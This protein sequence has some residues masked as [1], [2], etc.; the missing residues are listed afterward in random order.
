MNKSTAQVI[1]LFIVICLNGKNVSAQALDADSLIFELDTLSEVVVVATSVKRSANG[2]EYFVTK[3]MR[4]KSEGSALGLIATIPGVQLNKMNNSLSI[5]NRSNILLLINGKS[6]SVDYIRNVDPTNIVRITVNKN[7]KGQ[8]ASEGYDAVIDIKLRAFDGLNVNASNLLIVNPNNNSGD[9]VMMEQPGSSFTFSKNK[10]SFFGAYTYGNS[11]WN[12]PFDEALDY[13]DI[14]DAYGSGMDRY[15]YIGNVGNIGMNYNISS[16]QA[17]SFELDYRHENISDKKNISSDNVL[18]NQSIYTQSKTPV[19]GSTIFYKGVFGDKFDVYNEFGFNTLDN[20]NSNYL[21]SDTEQYDFDTKFK[22]SRRGLKYVTDINSHFSEVLSLNFGYQLN[23][24]KYSSSSFHYVN[25]GNKLWAYLNYTPT[26]IFEL[27][28]GAALNHEYMDGNKYF[29][30]LPSFQVQY[31]PSSVVNFQVSYAANNETPTLFMLNP[32]LTALNP[33][34]YQVGNI[35]LKTCVNHRVELSTTLFNIITFSPRYSYNRNKLLNYASL[36][37]DRIIFQYT[38]T[39][40]KEASFPISIDYPISDFL[41]LSVGGAYYVSKGKLAGN[42]RTID[43][44]WY[45]GN[46]TFFK[47]GYMADLGYSRT[48]VKDNILQGYTQSGI[49][50]WTLTANKQWFGGNLT[51]TLTWFMPLKWGV[52]ESLS[53]VRLTDFYYENT[54]MSM[55]PYRNAMIFQVAYRFDSGKAKK[56]TKRNGIENEK[57]IS[58]GLSF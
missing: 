43:G 34:V 26:K 25:T 16:S 57:R 14:K 35:D 45:S 29:N 17:L 30:V 49:D 4:Q 33:N 18:L 50:S 13:L 58:G 6:Y 12:T 22:E 32:T 24:R 21:F 10:V 42:T 7:P 51:T 41:N 2:D 8:Y 38:N 40:V 5:N 20:N 9:F 37:D 19:F 46:I 36:T 11:H 48:A 53:T 3:R 56:T 1:I 44:W 52:T 28:A 47:N 55:K 15:K 54:Q 27:T 39:L 31:N 23:W